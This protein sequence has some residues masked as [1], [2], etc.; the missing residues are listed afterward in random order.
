MVNVPVEEFEE[1]PHDCDHSGMEGVDCVT[2]G[3]QPILN[4]LKPYVHVGGWTR[5]HCN[6]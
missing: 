5:I 6:I 1:K 4:L 3:I 2:D